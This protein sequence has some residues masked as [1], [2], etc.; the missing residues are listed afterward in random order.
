M[1]LLQTLNYLDS[2]PYAIDHTWDTLEAIQNELAAHGIQYERLTLNQDA[3]PVDNP[4]AEDWLEIYP[5]LTSHLS[6]A[7]IEQ[8][9]V[10]PCTDNAQRETGLEEQIYSTH[11]IQAVLDGELLFAFRTDSHIHELH[12]HSGDLILLPANTPFWFDVGSNPNTTLLR[13]L[14]SEIAPRAERTGCTIV[15]GSSR[16]D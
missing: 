14:P 8:L 6:N 13:A 12:C 5:H 10:I 4:T 7:N 9:F 15:N 11:M 2:N 3:F 16:L 1:P